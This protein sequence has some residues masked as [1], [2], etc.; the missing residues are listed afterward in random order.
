MH[1]PATVETAELADGATPPMRQGVARAAL[2]SG[3]T[4]ATTRVL[5]I[6]LS[7][8][9][10]RA[11]LP[12]Q[13]GILGLAVIVVGIV[14]LVAACSETAGIVADMKGR[15]ASTRSLQRSFAV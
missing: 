8:A 9:T 4:G 13:V 15:T 7:I 14:S 1:N 10:A 3:V 6:I 2:A 11:L 12:S 5:T